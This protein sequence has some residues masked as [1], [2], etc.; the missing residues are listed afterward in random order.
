ME[1]GHRAAT[2]EVFKEIKSLHRSGSLMEVDFVAVRTS[3]NHKVRQLSTSGSPQVQYQA[4]K[5][6]KPP[7]I[8]IGAGIWFG[9]RGSEVQILSPRPFFSIT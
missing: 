4:H 3:M 5:N 9:T 2:A 6:N 8:S 1:A 7:Q